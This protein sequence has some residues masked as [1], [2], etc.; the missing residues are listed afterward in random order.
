L[1]SYELNCHKSERISKNVTVCDF[2]D[3]PPIFNI[4][5]GA[6]AA[7]SIINLVEHTGDRKC[8]NGR[9]KISH[10]HSILM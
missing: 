10:Y 4:K 2:F 8:L 3:N 1:I 5:F 6:R 7:R 9:G